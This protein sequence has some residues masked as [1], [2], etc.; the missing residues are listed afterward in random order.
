MSENEM[1]ANSM[2]GNVEEENVLSMVDVLEE[3]KQLEDD[4]N[5]VLGASDDTNCTYPHGYVHRQALYSCHTCAEAATPGDS[6]GI[7][8]ACSL[9]CHEGHQLY[10]LYTKRSFRC[11]CGNEKFPT[12][13]KCKLSA[14]KSARNMDNKYNHNFHGAYCTCSRPYPDPEDEV[15]DEM[16]QCVV[17]EDWFHGRHLGTELPESEEYHEMICGSCMKSCEFLWPYFVHGVEVKVTCSE[18]AAPVEV[19]KEEQD[20]TTSNGQSKEVSA[21]VEIKGAEKERKN[22]VNGK[23]KEQSAYSAAPNEPVKG[24][25]PAVSSGSDMAAG[26]SVSNEDVVCRLKELKKREFQSRK[27]A[28]FWKNGWRSKLCSCDSCKEM[29]LDKKVSFLTDETDTIISYENRGKGD[30]IGSSS[31]YEKGMH[32]LSKMHRTQQVDLLH[33]FNDMK[34]ELT[35]YLKKF[36]ENGKVVRAE[37]IKEFFGQMEARKKQRVSVPFNCR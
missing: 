8:L 22:G 27:G 18:T 32:E 13:F 14:D 12:D 34:S 2:E 5:A 31:Q 3:E 4:A 29:Y 23:D 11:D 15:E 10:E 19:V 21:L 1:T 25:V 30:G 20:C 26:A 36:A 35:E 7:C 28:T 33:G 9:E 16:I 37:D 24:E 17:C 6:A